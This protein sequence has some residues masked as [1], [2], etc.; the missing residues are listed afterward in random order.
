[1]PGCIFGRM[2][3]YAQLIKSGMV[4]HVA[5]RGNYDQAVFYAQEDYRRYLKLL[6]RYSC[7]FELSLLGWCLMTNHVHLLVRSEAADSLSR[8]MKRARISGWSGTA[9]SSCFD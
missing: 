3:R 9:R 6:E 7:E 2:P 5:A 8:A 4:L 1:M